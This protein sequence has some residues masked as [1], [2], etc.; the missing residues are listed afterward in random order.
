M[1]R[2]LIQWQEFC[3]RIASEKTIPPITQGIILAFILVLCC[4]VRIATIGSAPVDR[5]LWKEMDYVMI[6]Q[7]Y[8]HHGFNILKPEVWWPAEPPRI[9]IMEFPLAPFA[10]SI[11]YALFG[12]SA[13]TARLIPLI[14]Y[15][16]LSLYVFKL[17]KR[18]VGPIAGL[19]SAFA[20]SVIPLYNAFGNI[21]FS[22][23]SLIA[24]SVI[25]LYHFAQWTDFRRRRDWISA[26]VAFSL[27][28]A[29]K[30]EPLYL[31]L[32]L[33][34]IAFRKNRFDMRQYGGF[35]LLIGFALVL[36][37]AWFSYAYNHN[38]DL[39][40]IFKGH[41]RLQSLA[42]LSN[43]TWYKIMAHRIGSDILG[44][45]IGTVLFIL[46]LC[47]MAFI[48]K[49]GLLFVYLLAIVCYFGI[50]AEG[51]IDA[52]YRQLHGIAPISFFEAAGAVFL[53]FIATSL[54][55]SIWPHRKAAFQSKIV[56]MVIGVCA[57]AIIP[58]RNRKAIFDSNPFSHTD[59]NRW[60]LAQILRKEA[61]P[62]AKIIAAGEYSLNEG[63]NDVSPV[64]YYFSGL[65]G[66]TIQRDQWSMD[67]VS[68]LINKGATFFAATQMSRE[69]DATPFLQ[70][71]RQRYPVVFEDSAKEL[72]LLRL[73]AT[74]SNAAFDSTKTS[75]STKNR[76][77]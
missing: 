39:W 3:T 35:G 27:A 56:I 28:V 59:M 53:S 67:T 22:E 34:W 29:L 17:V 68:N 20:V 46:G 71:M 18:E 50:I 74:G 31:L 45:R 9:I 19:L 30:L 66:W 61:K 41:D 10:A 76:G 23:P 43:A 65:Q 8:W 54:L 37:A 51:N 52:P 48:K 47:S 6:S 44:G 12:F 26:M 4:C 38:F 73:V 13:L 64:L 5:T 7:N 58:L 36:P 75:T 1:R 60:Q 42:L 40:G 63:G 32:P 11:L 70:K 62:N 16:V 14:S 21:L 33:F 55:S 25:S 72:L 77:L 49:S 15:L 57:L 69:P 24:F 2:F